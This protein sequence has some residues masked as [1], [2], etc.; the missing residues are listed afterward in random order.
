[1]DPKYIKKLREIDTNDL[2]SD[3]SNIFRKFSSEST[4]LSLAAA[5]VLKKATE[6]VTVDLTTVDRFLNTANINDELAAFI[7]NSLVGSWDEISAFYRKYD[8][9]KL[10]AFILFH[11]NYD[12]KFEADHTPPALPFLS[13]DSTSIALKSQ[14]EETDFLITL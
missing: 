8:Q 1:M 10:M 5:Y 9:E 13:S 3:L 2:E 12:Y 11:E 7:T 14:S 4:L 6:S